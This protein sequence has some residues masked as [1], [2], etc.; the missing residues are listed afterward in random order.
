MT[1]R[2]ITGAARARVAPRARVRPLAT[3]AA[4]TLAVA[5]MMTAAT[6]DASAR[7]IY[8]W[9]NTSMFM[10]GPKFD[11]AQYVIRPRII[12]LTNDGS[13]FLDSLRWSHWGR[14]I[15]TASGT[16]G[17]SNGIPSVA[18]GK[19][20]HHKARVA[21]SNRGT[22]KHHRVYRCFTLSARLRHYWDTIENCLG[23]VGKYWAMTST[24]SAGKG[25]I[26][27]R[28]TAAHARFATVAPARSLAIRSLEDITVSKYSNGCQY[29]GATYVHR[30]A[31]MTIAEAPAPLT[32]CGNLGMVT[33][34]GT[35]TIDG[36][37]A[38]L[39]S[40]G[41]THVD[42]NLVWSAHGTSIVMSWGHVR[43]S[44]VI[45]MARGMKVV[46]RLRG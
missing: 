34:T 43:K 33:P 41:T 14:P 7:R 28:A 30:K 22:F 20:T 37:T 29:I 36:T 18:T 15:A 45:S 38:Q 3:V 12:N 44:K 11:R 40:C 4:F 23:R 25:I 6:A 2:R 35:V 26:A 5:L 24:P 32:K 19:V 10:S 31:R 17:V 39:Y 1:R 16:E 42:C 46:K 9:G 27:W 21:L 13:K 8:F